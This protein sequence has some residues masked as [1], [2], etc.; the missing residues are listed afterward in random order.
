M[1]LEQKVC[2]K[3]NLLLYSGLYPLSLSGENH[4]KDPSIS[5]LPLRFMDP[6]IILYHDLR[7]CLT[8]DRAAFFNK[9]CREILP[10]FLPF[11][12]FILYFLMCTENQSC[13]FP[14]GDRFQELPPG[15]AACFESHLYSG[16]KVYRP[17]KK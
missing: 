17:E 11:C 9:K 13:P 6:P 16:G 4:I 10:A 1:Y 3:S 8:P 12:H 7:L 5:C 14:S 15:S 2:S